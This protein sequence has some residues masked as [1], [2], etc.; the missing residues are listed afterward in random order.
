MCLFSIT[1]ILINLF[2]FYFYLLNLNWKVFKSF[3]FNFK[4]TKS[5][6][7]LTPNFRRFSA[8]MW[9]AMLNILSG[10][11][12][13]AWTPKYFLAK[14]AIIRNLNWFDFQKIFFF[15][16]FWRKIKNLIENWIDSWMG[17]GMRM[18]I[19]F[20]KFTPEWELRIAIL[21]KFRCEWE[22]E[23]ELPR[24]LDQLLISDFTICVWIIIT[25]L[26]N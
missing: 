24:F 25:I 8:N 22:W 4:T 10:P 7:V 2:T 1:L 9:P 12:D 26:V 13:V 3:S 11:A 6:N 20:W 15:F 16:H 5:E 19:E 21:F 18:G 23:W 14:S 17:M